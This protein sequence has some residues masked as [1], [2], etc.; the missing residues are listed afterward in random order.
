MDKKLQSIRHSTSHVLAQAALE[1]FPDIKL[2]IG[3]AIEEGFYYD[4]DL[5]GKTLTENDLEAL[6]K[7]MRHII[8]QH[9]TFEQFEMDVDEAIA[10]L[11]RKKQP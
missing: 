11:K 10:E 4:F 9:Q 5:G 6:E 3:P 7:K 8:K 2:A 1:L